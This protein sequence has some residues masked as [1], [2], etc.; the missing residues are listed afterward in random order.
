M[1]ELSYIQSDGET[2]S[3]LLHLYQQWRCIE[4]EAYNNSCDW[5]HVVQYTLFAR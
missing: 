4:K 3:I 2:K 1:C 5:D